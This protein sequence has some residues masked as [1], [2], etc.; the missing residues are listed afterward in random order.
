MKV[1]ELFDKEIGENILPITHPN[2]V[3][4]EEGRNEYERTDEAILEKKQELGLVDEVRCVE[5][6]DEEADKNNITRAAGLAKPKYVNLMEGGEFIAYKIENTSL[7]SDP[8]YSRTIKIEVKP[9]TCYYINRAPGNS[10]PSLNTCDV[11]LESDEGVY[12]IP[13]NKDGSERSNT[14]LYQIF[15]NAGVIKTRNDSKYL[16][17][18]LARYN[19][20]A[21]EKRVWTNEY[22]IEI[23]HPVLPSEYYETELYIKD[24]V[25]A[26]K[27]QFKVLLIGSSYGQNTIC[28]LPQIALDAGIDIVVGNLYTGSISLANQLTMAENDTSWTEYWHMSR[29]GNLMK[30]DGAGEYSSRGIK[31]TVR[32]VLKDEDWDVVVLMRSASSSNAGGWT[33]EDSENLQGLIDFI[34]EN[35]PSHPRVLWNSGFAYPLGQSATP[36][37]AAQQERSAQMITDAETI[38]A[39][40]GIDY[41]PVATA[42]Q[43]CRNDEVVNSSEAAVPDL[44]DGNIHLNNGIGMYITACCLFEY[45]FKPLFG[46]S[47]RTQTKVPVYNNLKYVYNDGNTNL[48]SSTY[49]LTG[50]NYYNP[51]TEQ[52][53]LIRKYAQI[54]CQ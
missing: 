35:C 51:T 43:L 2:A 22:C 31:P 38:K 7:T 18:E 54:A 40:I 25:G 14:T 37:R 10:S 5:I 36:N 3:L 20:A 53:R 16:Y 13:L 52:A 42:L 21:N 4:D 49:V 12:S 46:M 17:I 28:S 44:T 8:G 33:D 41:I 39:T 1:R 23:D 32:E 47:I 48:K 34:E 29:Y 19:G 26:L 50:A 15:P 30:G 24:G 6:F 27:K 11:L 9:D 45:F